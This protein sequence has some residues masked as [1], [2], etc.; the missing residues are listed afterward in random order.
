M[1]SGSSGSQKTP[2]SGS[3]GGREVF[4]SLHDVFPSVLK[5]GEFLGSKYAHVCISPAGSWLFAAALPTPAAR[6]A[7]RGC[8]IPS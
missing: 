4:P 1:L 5:C 2:R 6:F 8:R 7:Q 3:R